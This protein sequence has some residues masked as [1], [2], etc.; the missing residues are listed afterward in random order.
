[1]ASF[2]HAGMVIIVHCLQR[3][4]FKYSICLEYLQYESKKIVDAVM[5]SI[6]VENVSIDESNENVLD[7]DLSNVDDD[8]IMCEIFILKFIWFMTNYAMCLY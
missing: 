6:P 7:D 5:I 1:M 8:A 2:W 3:Y 4:Q